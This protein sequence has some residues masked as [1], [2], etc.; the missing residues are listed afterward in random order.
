MK[1]V[2]IGA[3]SEGEAIAETWVAFCFIDRGFI[4]RV[5]I[6]PLLTKER[7]FA[8]LE[9]MCYLSGVLTR[10]IRFRARMSR[11]PINVF[12]KLR[13]SLSFP[14]VSLNTKVIATEEQI[15]DGLISEDVIDKFKSCKVVATPL[16]WSRRYSVLDNA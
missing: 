7:E 3:K 6:P 1:G 5:I 10:A 8:D 14:V 12:R 15:E 2:F 9:T 16:T 4:F 11:G 13:I